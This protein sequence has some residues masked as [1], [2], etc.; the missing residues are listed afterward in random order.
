M[1]LSASRTLPVLPAAN[2]MSQGYRQTQAKA[3]SFLLILHAKAGGLR[4]SMQ[5]GYSK[6]KAVNREDKRSRR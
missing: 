3:H 2:K 6:T 5:F 4:I 1:R